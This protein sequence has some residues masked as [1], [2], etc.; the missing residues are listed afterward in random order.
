MK[1]D[2]EEDE[3]EKEGEEKGR[4]MEK[5][6]ERGSWGRM[7]G[8]WTVDKRENGRRRKVGR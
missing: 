1:G 4:E 5:K 6:K 3:E 2:R 8:R 7:E